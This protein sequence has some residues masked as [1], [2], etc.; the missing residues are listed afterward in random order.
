MADVPPTEGWLQKLTA[1]A[2]QQFK[3]QIFEGE[4]AK[5]LVPPPVDSGKF[6]TYGFEQYQKLCKTPQPEPDI[7][8]GTT[9]KIY[10]QVKHWTELSP[11]HAEGRDWAG[12]THEDLAQAVGVS[13]KQVQRIVSKPPFHTITKVIEKRTRKLFR[14]GAPSDMT[15]EDFARI[16]VADWRKATGRKEKR[17][18]FGLLVGMVKDAPIGLAPD[19]LRTVVENWSGFSAGVGLAVEVAKVEG[20]AFDGNAEHFEKKFFHYP[21]ISVTRRFWPVAIEFYH[22]FIQENLGKGPILYDQIDKILNNHEIQSP[23]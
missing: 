3:K 5:P 22:M 8:N 1:V 2:K 13:S 10:A 23:F 20:D 21:A 7:L 11:I 18:D 19:I 17:D 6:T 9:K 12:I 4:P 14:I 15:H 16:M